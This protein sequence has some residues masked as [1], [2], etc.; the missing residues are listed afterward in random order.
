MIRIYVGNLNYDTTVES[1]RE[2]FSDFGEISEAEIISNPQTGRS[3]GYGF[4][5]MTDEAAGRKAIESLNGQEL[6]GR[7][8]QVNVAKPRPG[9]ATDDAGS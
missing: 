3:R 9:Y 7:A 5:Q 8:L 6:D 1:L 2:L 4:V